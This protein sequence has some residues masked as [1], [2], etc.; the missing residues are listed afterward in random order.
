[1]KHSNSGNDQPGEVRR[2]A[3]VGDLLERGE[4][5]TSGALILSAAALSRVLA[6]RGFRA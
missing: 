2:Q 1:M 3:W 5:A 4:G 6:R